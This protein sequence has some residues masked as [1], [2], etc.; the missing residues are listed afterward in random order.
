MMQFNI[1]QAIPYTIAV[2][3]AE[4]K[5]VIKPITDPAHFIGNVRILEKIKRIIT[6]LH[7]IWVTDLGPH[8]SCKHKNCGNP[9]CDIWADIRKVR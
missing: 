9:T 3:E 8:T 5:S 7:Y 6:A 4:H 2:T 1:T